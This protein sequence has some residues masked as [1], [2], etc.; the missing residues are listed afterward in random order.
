MVIKLRVR[1]SQLS[2]EDNW[3]SNLSFA[4]GRTSPKDSKSVI[5]QN[6]GITARKASSVETTFVL[7]MVGFPQHPVTFSLLPV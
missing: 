2:H 7:K 4:A 5:V 3:E 1:Y 6:T